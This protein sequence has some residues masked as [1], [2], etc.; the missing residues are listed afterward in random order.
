[1]PAQSQA[2]GKR[3]RQVLA[4]R[5]ERSVRARFALLLV[6]IRQNLPAHLLRR[7]PT[8]TAGRVSGQVSGRHAGGRG[9]TE[10]IGRQRRRWVVRT[11]SPGRGRVLRSV[12]LCESLEVTPGAWRTRGREDERTRGREDD[13][14]VTANR[15][16]AWKVSFTHHVPPHEIP[17]RHHRMPTANMSMARIDRNRSDRIGHRLCHWREP[18][19][20]AKLPD[21]ANIALIRVPNRHYSTRS[22]PVNDANGPI[23]EVFSNRPSLGRNTS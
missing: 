17:Y 11:E 18:V 14:C 12:R 20:R 16:S 19:A 3:G 1:M 9:A 23:A 7:L 21:H 8:P 5:A 13:A 10:L 6:G 4:C 2:T 15:T 22:T